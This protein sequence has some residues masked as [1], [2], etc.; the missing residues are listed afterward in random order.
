MPGV[1][2]PDRLEHVKHKFAEE[3][4]NIGDV[5]MT[6]DGTHVPWTPEKGRHSEDYHN[7]KGWHSILCL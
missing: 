7:Y 3:R 5:A 6:V 4:H 1:P 2:C